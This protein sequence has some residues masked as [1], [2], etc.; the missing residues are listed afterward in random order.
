MKINKFRE[1]I[2]KIYRYH[3][4]RCGGSFDEILCYEIHTQPVNPRMGCKTFTNGYSTG[5]TF[6]ELAKKWGISVSFL[7]DL[8]S[9]HCKNLEAKELYTNEIIKK[10]LGEMR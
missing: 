9:D 8:I 2:E 10:N 4:T 5:L 6:K 7:G 3:P 1:H